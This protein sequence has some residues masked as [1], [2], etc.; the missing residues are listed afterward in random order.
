[1]FGYDYV[2][3]LVP[4]FAF[5]EE[6]NLP[7]YFSSFLLLMA[8]G[9]LTLQGEV[10]RRSRAKW[11]FHWIGMGLVFAFLALD[12]ALAL[13][14]QLMAPVRTLL[15][16][17]GLLY[18]AWIIPYAAVS[19]ILAVVYVRF[20]LDLRADTRKRFVFAAI[21][22]LLGAVALEAIS[23]SIWERQ[24]AL[25]PLLDLSVF[26]EDVFEMG[27]VIVFIWA[28]ADELARGAVNVRFARAADGASG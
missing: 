14:E 13:H 15:G 23:G 22:F 3:G 17:S 19:S 12:E 16:T 11:G 6:H 7:S 24:R 8:A 4:L 2:F 5:V 25:S 20:F 10:L 18:A 21:L 9:L 1:V 26:L 28:I 27:G